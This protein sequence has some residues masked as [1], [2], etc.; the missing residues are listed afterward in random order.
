[1]TPRHM[2]TG[3]SRDIETSPTRRKGARIY[4]QNMKDSERCAVV[5]GEEDGRLED[6]SVCRSS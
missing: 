1:M 4:S 6:A 2:P 5:K 3:D